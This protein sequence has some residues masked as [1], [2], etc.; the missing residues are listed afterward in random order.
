MHK[1]KRD[2][3][4]AWISI[5]TYQCFALTVV[6]KLSRGNTVEKPPPLVMTPSSTSLVCA[7]SG[8]GNPWVAPTVMTYGQLAGNVAALW[9]IKNRSQNYFH[10][11]S[12]EP[13]VEINY[14]KWLTGHNTVLMHFGYTRWRLCHRLQQ[15]CWHLEGQVFVL[16]HK[17]HAFVE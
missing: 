6:W 15:I 1:I 14:L 11:Q 3:A 13:K 8:P 2:N 9:K 5:N 12:G 17:M 7:I 10:H 4:S 16:Q